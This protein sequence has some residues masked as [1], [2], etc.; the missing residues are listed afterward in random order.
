MEAEEDR[1]GCASLHDI[2]PGPYALTWLPVDTVCAYY[3]YLATHIVVLRVVNSSVAK[4]KGFQIHMF[5][6]STV[7]AC[8]LL[9]Q[10]GL[11]MQFH[12]MG[13]RDFHRQARQVLHYPS[14]LAALRIRDAQL[15]TFVRYRQFSVN[16]CSP[17]SPRKSTLDLTRMIR[18]TVAAEPSGCSSTCQRESLLR[19]ISSEVE[20]ASAA[21]F[22]NSCAILNVTR[23]FADQRGR[24]A[25]R[26]LYL[27]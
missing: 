4:G 12:M 27:L 3:A 9:I 1:A 20:P 10:N 13:Q 5:N 25:R 24:R 11:I 14:R 17:R 6:H 21:L 8:M 18:R 16:A 15:A 22:H 2:L 19:S 23:A 26:L 7:R